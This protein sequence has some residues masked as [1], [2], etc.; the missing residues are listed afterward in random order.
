[1][2]NRFQILLIFIFSFISLNSFCQTTPKESIE[3]ISLPPL[4][5]FLES[6]YSHPSTEVYKTYKTEEESKL[7]IDKLQWLNYLRV[8]GNYQYGKNNLFITDMGANTGIIG[9]PNDAI[10]SFGVGVSLSI[11]IGDVSTQHNKAKAQQAVVDRV[12]YQYE[13][14]IEERK[15]KILEA[16]NAVIEELS[17]LKA[18]AEAAAIY[19]AQMKLSEE[20]FV[21]GSITIEELSTE[22]ARRANAIILYQEG[23]ASLH[24][25]L[26][27]L[28]LLTGVKIIN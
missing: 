17:T 19:N 22:R 14:A 7:K 9:Y 24:N 28:E 25:A 21:N 26:T 23:R 20:A 2:T 18:K 13:I 11:P 8:I 15:L 4:S 16:Y 3:S 5:V 6:A 12:N 1:M 10:S 27:L